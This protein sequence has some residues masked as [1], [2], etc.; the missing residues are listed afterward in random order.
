MKDGDGALE[1]G[2]VREHDRKKSVHSHAVIVEE[3]VR[4]VR[5]LRLG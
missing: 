2:K 3:E 4:T 5:E 1:A